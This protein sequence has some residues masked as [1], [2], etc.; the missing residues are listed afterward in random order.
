MFTVILNRRCLLA[1]MLLVLSVN[2]TVG[3]RVGYQRELE[4]KLFFSNPELPAYPDDCGAG[5]FVKRKIPATRQVADAALKM[6]FK[7]PT[8]EE[9]ANGMAGNAPLGDYY[10]GVKI[11]KGEAIVNFRRGA[12]KYLHVSGAICEQEMVLTPIVKTLKQFSPIKSVD[13]AIEGRIITEWDA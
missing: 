12:E 8:V 13:Y 5:V 6:L 10:L 9:K 1:L 11:K 3:Y 2:T 7:G 4:I